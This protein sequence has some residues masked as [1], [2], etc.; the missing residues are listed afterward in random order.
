MHAQIIKLK[1]DLSAVCKY[2]QIADLVAEIASQARKSLG[3]SAVLIEDKVKEMQTFREEVDKER[4]QVATDLA[5]SAAIREE[6]AERIE[7]LEKSELQL[8]IKN[9]QLKTMVDDLHKRLKGRAAPM[10]VQER[11][12]ESPFPD[13][14][15]APDVKHSAGELA[16]AAIPAIW[17]APDTKPSAQDLVQAVASSTLVTD[18]SARSALSPLSA[19]SS[20]RSRS[21]LR[22]GKERAVSDGASKAV[23][24]KVKQEEDL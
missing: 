15:Q 7:E 19:S 9:R 23:H 13:T 21:R 4:M 24:I 22:S 11:Q 18:T 10:S 1:E 5:M 20:S 8:Q 6:T 12:E 16:K 17:D 3:E 2:L 14:L